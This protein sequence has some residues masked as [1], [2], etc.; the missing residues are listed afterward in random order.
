MACHACLATLRIASVLLSLGLAH[1]IE[2]E[3]LMISQLDDTLMETLMVAPGK[4][5]GITCEELS[6]K[7]TDL[8]GS[9]N[10]LVGKYN[11]LVN[12]KSQ[13]IQDYNALLKKYQDLIDKYNHDTQEAYDK[14]N[15]NE[16]LRVQQVNDCISQLQDCNANTN[17][18]R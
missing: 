12:D 1:R 4:N 18:T 3:G 14:Y 7:Y 16:E 8:H 15:A 17:T 10:G 13:V 11:Q 6:K 5:S 9:Y 2:N